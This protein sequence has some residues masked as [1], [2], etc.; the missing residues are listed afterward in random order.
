MKVFKRIGGWFEDRTGFGAA[1]KPILDHKVPYTDWKSGWW[2]VFGSAV[3]ISFVIQIISGIAL[4]TSYVSSAGEAYNSLK[5]ITDQAV[6]GGFLRGVHAWGASAMV[7]LVG[8]HALHV[9]IIGSY[10]FP[11]EMNWL[12]GAVLLLMTLAMAFTGQLL[13]W[14]DTAF[15]SIFVGAN[16]AART[17]FL[18][19]SLA[20]FILAGDSVGGATLS[21]FFAFHVFFIPGIIFA[22]IGA[23]LFLVIRNGI[24]EPP[25]I[26][27]PVNPKTYRKN[28][29]DL[30]EREGVPF[31]PDALWRDAVGAVVVIVAVILLAIVVGPPALGNQPDPANLRVYPR[32]DWYFLWYFSVLA[33]IPAQAESTVILLGPA[34]VG[35]MLILL[36]LIANKGERHPLRRPW[37]MAFVLVLVVMIA[38]FWIIGERSPWSPKFDA[39]PLPA[40]LASTTDQQVIIGQRLFSER[41]CQYCH[42]VADNVEGGLRGPNLSNV[43]NRLSQAQLTTRILNGG[44]NMPAYSTA[45]KPDEINALVA[46]LQT[47]KINSEIPGNNNNNR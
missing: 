14:D 10:K 27:D 30:L 11:R 43:G 31:W 2:Y 47:R 4:S 34:L 16:Q 20:K 17:P 12:T 41:G 24:S 23:H 19:E 32:P 21:R 7:L 6:L 29:H 44:N 46:F 15:W 18:G 8:A 39:Q 26:G 45:L 40:N 5:F 38:T 35:V 42:V 22:F 9:F 28:Y 33:L 1:I 25:K 36:P 13:R 37:A 3:L